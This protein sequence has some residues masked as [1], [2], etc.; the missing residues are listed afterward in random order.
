MPSLATQT[1]SFL[2]SCSYSLSPSA[3]QS[4]RSLPLNSS[5]YS[6]AG[7]A[8]LNGTSSNNT[9]S[10]QSLGMADPLWHGIGTS[11][12]GDR[13]RLSD[14]GGGC[15]RGTAVGKANGAGCPVVGQPDPTQAVPSTD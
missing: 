5:R 14:G 6:S 10:T 4:S 13:V 9:S 11:A 2:P 15:N 12:S 7:R 8:G 3:T 1:G